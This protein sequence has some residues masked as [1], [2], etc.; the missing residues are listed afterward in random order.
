MLRDLGPG[1]K[2]LYFDIF[3]SIKQGTSRTDLTEMGEG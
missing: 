1:K 3:S 2:A